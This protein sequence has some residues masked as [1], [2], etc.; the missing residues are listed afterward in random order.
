MAAPS[1]TADSSLPRGMAGRLIR[2][3]H[4]QRVPQARDRGRQAG[5]IQPDHQAAQR[6]Q[7][8]DSTA[9]RD[10]I[11]HQGAVPATDS[12]GLLYRV[13]LPK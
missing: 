13:P 6:Q 2:H 11:E 7:R 3:Y 8:Q 4:M 9:N 10:F 12:S 5:P 1:V